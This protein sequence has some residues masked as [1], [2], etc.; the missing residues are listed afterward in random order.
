[1]TELIIS[2]ARSVFYG[3]FWLAILFFTLAILGAFRAQYKKLA[4]A[5]SKAK[6]SS[7]DI[8]FEELDKAEAAEKENP[9]PTYDP[10][11]EWD[12]VTPVYEPPT[13]I[14]SSGPGPAPNSRGG[15]S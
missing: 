6:L 5:D 12:D 10:D 1:M 7:L 14:Y 11:K 3:V 8:D 13:E 2:I 15:Y 9:S 4:E